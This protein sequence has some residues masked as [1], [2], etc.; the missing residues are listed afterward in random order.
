MLCIVTTVIRNNYVG[1]FNVL[2]LLQVCLIKN[3]TTSDLQEVKTL[4]LYFRVDAKTNYWL[5]LYIIYYLFHIK[6]EVF[7]SI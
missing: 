5:P 3:E 6:N 1:N 7:K 2:S 4:S